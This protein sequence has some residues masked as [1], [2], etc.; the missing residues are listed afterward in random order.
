MPLKIL[1]F[2]PNMGKINDKLGSFHQEIKQIVNRYQGRITKNMLADYDW[3]LQR[4][5]DTMYSISG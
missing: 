5:S 2:P 1:F 4:E 3:F